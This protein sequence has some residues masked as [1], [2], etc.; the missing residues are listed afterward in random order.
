M[1]ALNLY[2]ASL[3]VASLGL[4]ASA[5]AIESAPKSTVLPNN[6]ATS[7]AAET[8]QSDRR[9]NI[10]GVIVVIDRRNNMA[11][12]RPKSG[13]GLIEVP[14]RDDLTISGLKSG[15]ASNLRRG[16]EV[17]LR[18]FVSA[19]S[20]E[21]TNTSDATKT[22]QG[23]QRMNVKGV[24]V[25]IDKN[26]NI[27]KVRSKSSSDL[28]EVELSDKLKISGLRSGRGNNLQEGDEVILYFSSL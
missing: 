13:P 18:Y 14:L 11:K 23:D 2:T 3:L 26:K 9:V 28:I 1:K 20:S 5:N 10:E 4:A 24:I 22:G 16:D 12:V 19:D 6:A 17:I 25:A 7:S 15:N 21:K 8:D 27:A